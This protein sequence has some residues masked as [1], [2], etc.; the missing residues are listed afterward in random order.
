MTVL[1]L[2][3][4]HQVK[5]AVEDF[6]GVQQAPPPPPKKSNQILDQNA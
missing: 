5:Y 3:T 4:I 6:E 2:I 1:L